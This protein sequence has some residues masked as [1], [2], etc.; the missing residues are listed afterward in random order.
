MEHLSPSPQ[1]NAKSSEKGIASIKGY[2]RR[3][4]EPCLATCS[5]PAHKGHCIVCLHVSSPEN[6]L[7]AAWLP[8]VSFSQP[9]LVNV[10]MLLSSSVHSLFISIAQFTHNCHNYKLQGQHPIKKA[11]NNPDQHTLTSKITQVLKARKI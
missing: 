10:C 5:F 4:G 8:H 7:M 2:E 11:V 1:Q 9:C 3:T 6:I